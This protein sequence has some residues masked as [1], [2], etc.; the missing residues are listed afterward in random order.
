M[1]ILVSNGAES[2]E[3]FD[4][5]TW[6]CREVARSDGDLSHHVL[7][8]VRGPISAH[9][10]NWRNLVAS[11]HCLS[12]RKKDYFSAIWEVVRWNTMAREFVDNI[13]LPSCCGETDA[14]REA[15][16]DRIQTKGTPREE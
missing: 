16:E 4:M 5:F 12:Y 7:D 3:A 1:R 6:S 11:L 10:L 15:Y 9:L 2:G 13:P 8:K 14:R